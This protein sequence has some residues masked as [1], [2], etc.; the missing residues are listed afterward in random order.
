MK[1]KTL[2]I[3]CLKS[4][5]NAISKIFTLLGDEVLI[6]DKDRWIDRRLRHIEKI[7][8]QVVDRIQGKRMRNFSDKNYWEEDDEK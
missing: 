5:E 3:N 7:L 8:L 4:S 1:N 6:R 2:C